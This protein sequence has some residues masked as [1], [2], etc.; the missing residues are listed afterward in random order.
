MSRHLHEARQLLILAAPL[1]L[2]QLLQAGMAFVDT[3]MVGRLGGEELAGMALGATTFM[4]T[5][6]FLQGIV[7]A[8]GPTVAHAFGGGRHDEVG[9][10]AW[11]GVWLA[12]LLAVPATFFLLNAEQLLLAM[13]QQSHSAQLAGSYL[14]AAAWGVA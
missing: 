4:F 14:D 9:R 10:T 2:A 12:L 1:A 7:F 6:I 11:Q 13:G 5:N 3:V 8:V